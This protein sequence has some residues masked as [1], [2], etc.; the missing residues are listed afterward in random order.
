M[1]ISRRA[2]LF[3]SVTAFVLLIS[4]MFSFTSSAKHMMKA[5]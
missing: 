2:K 4:F 3:S 5:R 1:K